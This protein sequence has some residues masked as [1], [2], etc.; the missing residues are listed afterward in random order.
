MSLLLLTASPIDAAEA[1]R[2]GLVEL[3]E[4][5]GGS[6]AVVAAILENDPDS[7]AVL[8]RGIRLAAHGRRGDAEQDRGFDAL[9]V[10]EALARRLEALRRK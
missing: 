1:A 3:N 9:I 5:E 8:K 2:I 7:L 4:P 6:G 10:S